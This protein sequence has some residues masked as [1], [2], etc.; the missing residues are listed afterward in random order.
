MLEDASI[1]N[2]WAPLQ[3]LF[4][5]FARPNP[6]GYKH[7]LEQNLIPPPMTSQAP[8]GNAADNSQASR[9]KAAAQ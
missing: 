4:D 6:L 2:A 5:D 7:V 3:N 9:P 8:A 1:N